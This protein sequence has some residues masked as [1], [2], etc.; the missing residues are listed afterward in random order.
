MFLWAIRQAQCKLNKLDP[1]MLRPSDIRGPFLDNLA[2][3]IERFTTPEKGR[4]VR[5]KLQALT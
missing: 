2:V 3:A 5:N 4:A 1:C